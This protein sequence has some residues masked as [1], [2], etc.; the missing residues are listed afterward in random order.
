MGSFEPDSNPE[1]NW[2]DSWEAVWNE[3][4][5]EQY[6]RREGDEVAKYQT[7]YDKLIR[8]Q[9]RLDEVALYMGWQS[10]SSPADSDGD[11]DLAAAEFP[12]P[13][14][15]TLHRHPLFVASKALHGWLIQ[16]WMQHVALCSEKLPTEKVMA[17]Q[18]TLAE[19]D[20]Y[21]LLAVTALDM[22][23]FA[24]AVAYLK[25]GMVAINQ[26]LALIAAF[27]AMQISP[28]PLYL[29]QA[30]VRLFDLREIWLRVSA[31]C[32]STMSR[33]AEEE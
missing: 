10:A 7:F 11:D 23:D 22:D 16:R 2:D 21:G 5:W 6:L 4:D 13:Q 28:L 3:F 31:D 19:S 33:G 9:N 30:R 32:R 14:P 12:D 29:S 25:R 15:Y 20:Y 1:S 8:S 17:Y 18:A 26:S 27:E 24:L